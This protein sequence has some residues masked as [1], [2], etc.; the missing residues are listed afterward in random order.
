MKLR[1][2]GSNPDGDQDSL[3]Q[4]SFRGILGRLV[5][6]PRNH[7]DTSSARQVNGFGFAESARLPVPKLRSK[8]REGKRVD[9]LSAGPSRENA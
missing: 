1:Q 6:V 4:L 2:A 8:V 5:T 9:H 7:Q 3:Y